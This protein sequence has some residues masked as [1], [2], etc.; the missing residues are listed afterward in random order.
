[1]DQRSPR[2]GRIHRT[3]R[4]GARRDNQDSQYQLDPKR[5]STPAV[6]LLTQRRVTLFYPRLLTYAIDKNAKSQPNGSDFS[7]L[8]KEP[9][10]GSSLVPA[11]LQSVAR[12]AFTSSNVGIASEQLWRD[13]TIAPAA[14]AKRRR[15]SG[16][17]P[18][19]S[20]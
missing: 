8:Q 16:S 20:P 11:P 9:R 4:S 17:Q 2:V 7:A 14:L 15:R 5:R 13:T 10:T 3:D 1:D 18:F 12:R 19:S 6:R